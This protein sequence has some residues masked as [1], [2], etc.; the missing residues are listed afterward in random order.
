MAKLVFS[1]GQYEGYRTTMGQTEDN[2]LLP[3]EQRVFA[4]E[5][6]RFIFEDLVKAIDYAS[7]QDIVSVEVLKG[8]NGSM[9][10][11]QKGQPEHPGILRQNVKIRLGEYIPAATVTESMVEE[12]LNAITSNSVTSAWELFARIAKLQPFDNGNKR[13][14]LIAANLLYGSF[15]DSSRDALSIPTDF[16]KLQFDTNL[17]YYYVADDLDDERPNVS[18]SLENFV[19]FATQLT[20]QSR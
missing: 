15:K 10:S 8:I 5:D 4:S 3:S 14:A 12:Q 17:I 7:K 1:L 11:K 6:D 9:D 2:L 19:T 13:T 20:L 16:K 18:E